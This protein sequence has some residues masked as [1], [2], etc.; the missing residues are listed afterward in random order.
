M[1]G[2]LAFSTDGQV[3]Q[4]GLT[5]TVRLALC[6]LSGFLCYRLHRKW[7]PGVAIICGLVIL[8][9]NPVSGYFV[10]RLGM[11]VI[12][13]IAGVVLMMVYS[14][15]DSVSDKRAVVNEATLTKTIVQSINKAIANACWKFQRR[16]KLPS[17]SISPARFVPSAFVT[18]NTGKA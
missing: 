14:H 10:G 13:I 7:L 1:A 15:I 8:A 12:D 9:C 16:Q 5:I 2:Y 4:S 6:L 18:S 11:I 17:T 3:T